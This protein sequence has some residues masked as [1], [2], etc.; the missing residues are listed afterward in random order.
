MRAIAKY[1]CVIIAEWLCGKG[2]HCSEKQYEDAL[3]AAGT[4]IKSKGHGH[5]VVDM[6]PI[7]KAGELSM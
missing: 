2:P 4:A 1:L 6:N 5:F 7:E 3:I